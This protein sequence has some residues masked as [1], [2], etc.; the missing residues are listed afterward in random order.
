MPLRFAR[1]TGETMFPPW[2]PFFAADGKRVTAARSKL[3]S[4]TSAGRSP[5]RSNASGALR[6][7]CWHERIA[8]DAQHLLARALLHGL[9][10]A[11]LEAHEL[12][13]TLHAHGLEPKV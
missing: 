2:A 13:A 4:A 1:F 11:Q 9:Q 5:P 8:D 10:A 6:S 12:D 7:G 3:R